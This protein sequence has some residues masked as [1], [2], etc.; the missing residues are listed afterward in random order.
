MARKEKKEINLLE[1]IP[2][3]GLEWQ[4]NDEGLIV[5]LKPKYRNPILAKHILPRL[6]NP[7]FKIRLDVTGSF[8]WE[9][10]D[11]IRSVKELAHNLKERF[12]DE[13]EPL[14]ERLTLFLQQLEKNR[15]ITYKNL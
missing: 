9:L 1:L 4:K 12:G 2:V 15:F 8:I 11:G 7:H 10:C 5:L 3:R 13:V 6:K 14:Y